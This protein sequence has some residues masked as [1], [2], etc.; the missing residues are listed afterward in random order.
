MAP[1]ALK[2]LDDVDRRILEVLWDDARQS[3]QAIADRV[4]VTEGTVRGR[5]KR[6]FDEGAVRV[7]ARSVAG[8]DSQ[9]LAYLWISC[10]RTR[11]REVAMALAADPT[12]RYVASLLGRADLMA[13]VARESQAD[14]VD[15]VDEKVKPL[16]GVTDV[17]VEP[18]LK[19]LIGDMRWGILRG[20]AGVASDSHT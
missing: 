14:L 16:E 18:V 4:G 11:L 8:L 10:D 9:V 3:H 2:P 7:T 17:R 15:Y 20:A 5:L 1:S 12:V 6:L 19:M 13:I